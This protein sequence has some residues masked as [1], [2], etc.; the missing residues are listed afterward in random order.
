MSESGVGWV[1]ALHSP[2]E[3]YRV[4]ILLVTKSKESFLSYEM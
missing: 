2:P 3:Y 1:T 4:C